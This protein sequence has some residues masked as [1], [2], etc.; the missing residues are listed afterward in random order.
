VTALTPIRSV[1]PQPPMPVREIA[2]VPVADVTAESV[3]AAL[4]TSLAAGVTVRLAF[5]NAHCVNLVRRDAR[6]RSALTKFLV[7]PDGVG[8]DLAGRILHGAPFRE[9]LNGTDFVP[10]LLAGLGGPL[11]VGLVGAAPGVAEAAAAR[12]AAD[13]PAHSYLPLSDG[14]FG[15]EPAPVLALLARERP[16]IVLV[17]MGVPAQELFIAG[18]LDERHGRLL[19][20]VGALFDFLAGNVVRAPLIVR[21]ARLEWLWRLGLEPGRLWRRYVLGNPLFLLDT[22]R[23]RLRRNRTVA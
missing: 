7:L 11:R 1:A 4:V 21:K 23:D 10:R 22:V 20:G 12:L 6:Y 3:I 18:H 2:G 19:I 8:I 14:F 5:L 17:A 9:N 15:D 13:I 16:D